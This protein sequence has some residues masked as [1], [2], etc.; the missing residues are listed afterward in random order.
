MGSQ[1]LI[2]G[3]IYE[4]IYE[5]S[6]YVKTPMVSP[7]SEHMFKINRSGKQP[8]EE[9]AILF[10][11]LVAKLLFVINNLRPYI[12]TTISFIITRL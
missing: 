5:L 12:K 9:R 2:I 8:S 7:A 1:L 11:W 3:Y 4:A 10:H 6:N